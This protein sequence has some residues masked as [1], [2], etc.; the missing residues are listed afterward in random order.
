M[1]NPSKVK[2]PTD[3]SLRDANTNEIIDKTEIPIRLN[4]YFINIGENLANRITPPSNIELANL[5][6]KDKYVINIDENSDML[7]KLELF[8]FSE[9]IP[10][11]LAH[12]TSCGNYKYS[13]RRLQ[14]LKFE[15]PCPL[16]T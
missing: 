1:V 3:L 9:F 6:A 5:A 15:I 4:Y 10:Y 13:F 16:A 12:D 7:Q 11:I 14:I 2:E 8:Y